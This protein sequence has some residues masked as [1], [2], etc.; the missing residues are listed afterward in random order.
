MKIAGLLLILAAAAPSAEE[1]TSPSADSAPL[2]QP[3]L[4]FEVVPIAQVGVVSGVSGIVE[5]LVE[6]DGWVPLVVGV[7]VGSGTKLRVAPDATF[8]LSFAS[9]NEV[10][11][12]RERRERWFVLDTEAP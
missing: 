8:T 7:N 9:G 4:T 2:E 1:S 12:K 3:L 5:V 10:E 11:L 6:E